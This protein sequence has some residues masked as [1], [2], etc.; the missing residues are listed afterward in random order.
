MR[1]RLYVFLFLASVLA[2]AQQ[3]MGVITGIITD[4]T[5][6]AVPGAVVQI[7]NQETNEIRSVETSETG[8]YTIGPLR[9]GTYAATVEKTGFKKSIMT[10]IRLSG[11]AACRFP[12]GTRT[13]C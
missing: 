12:S 5:G 3:D 2:V 9:I 1:R 11:P 7:M 4:A 8:T 6:A 13:D 10:G